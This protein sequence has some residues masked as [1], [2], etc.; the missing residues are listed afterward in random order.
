MDSIAKQI[1]DLAASSNPIAHKQ[2][3]DTLR[4]LSLSLE[5]PGDSIQRIIYGVISKS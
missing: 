2:I 4:D 5:T 3:L 1:Q